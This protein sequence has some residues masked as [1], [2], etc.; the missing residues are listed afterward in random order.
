M[1]KTILVFPSFSEIFNTK[2]RNTLPCFVAPAGISTRRKNP[3]GA[4]YFYVI[5]HAYVAVNFLF[6]LIFIFPLFQIHSHSLPYPK[7][8]EK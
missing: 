5:A 1:S 8:I 2:F 3:K 7:T 4:S 6:Q